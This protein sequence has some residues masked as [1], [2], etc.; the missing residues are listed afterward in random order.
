MRKKTMKNQS[1]YSAQWIILGLLLIHHTIFSATGAKTDYQP[2]EKENKHHVP[3]GELIPSIRQAKQSAR[4]GVT[5]YINPTAPNKQTRILRGDF[6]DTDGDGMTD[7]AEKKYGFNPNDRNSFPK[8]QP[9]VS[10]EPNVIIGDS[11]N[12]IS[13]TFANLSNAEKT[14]WSGFIDRVWPIMRA[15]LGPPAQ[16]F[17]CVIRNMGASS[18]YFMIVDDG[19]EFQCDGDFIPRLI[20]HEFVHAWKGRYSFTRDSDWEYHSDLSG[21]EEATGEGMAF[22]I[23]HEFVRSFP[24]DTATKQLLDWRPYQY[25]N[26]GTT[27]CDDMRHN[28]WTGAGD[29]WTHTGGQRVRYTIAATTWQIMMKKKPGFYPELMKKWYAKIKAEPNFRSNRADIMKLIKAEVPQ[30]NGVPTDVY[31]N[32]MPV[33]NGHK[34]DEGFYIVNTLRPFGIDGDQQFC[35]TYVPMDGDFWW[36]ISKSAM[37]GYHIPNWVPW[38]LGSDNYNYIDMM[39]QPFEIKVYSDNKLEGTFDA[40]TDIDYDADG[41]AS[42]L[43]WVNVDKVAMENF[44]I[45]LYRETVTFTNFL[46]HDTGAREDFYFFGLKDFEQNKATEYVIMIGVDGASTGSVKITIEGKD[47]TA[48]LVKGAAIFKSSDWPVDL[49]GEFPITVTSGGKTH[50]Y[51]RTVIEAGTYDSY[52]QHQFIVVDKNFDGVEDWY[53]GKIVS[54]DPGT[55]KALTGAQISIA[56]CI[57]A[58]TLRVNTRL[59]EQSPVTVALY[60]LSGKVILSHSYSGMAGN[61]I[62]RIPVIN[63]PRGICILRIAV[64]GY[65]ETKAFTI[66]K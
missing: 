11:G 26:N 23:I 46:E 29:F 14:I 43:G 53:Q 40:V 25:W 48:A 39:G 34:V 33:F 56:A 41:T 16:T 42:G 7:V 47:H 27:H 63:A 37:A 59:P 6:T 66:I 50:T 38:D 13:Y 30:V 5:G 62:Q 3:Y 51:F 12:Y 19:R 64:K 28:R 65:K 15:F 17:N 2:G 54:I 20:V 44:T 49:E 4:A 58:G 32:A 36:G 52:F 45:G 31:L 22:E 8:P 9:F 60:T 21:F 55:S 61:Q 35:A 57:S 24:N 18:G 1:H 10:S